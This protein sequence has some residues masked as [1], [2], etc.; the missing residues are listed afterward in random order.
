MKDSKMQEGSLYLGGIISQI[1]FIEG[2]ILTI[3]DSAIAEDRHNKATKDLVK[4]V[5]S[6]QMRWI[7]SL[8]N[9]RTNGG[10]LVH[11][12]EVEVT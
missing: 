4:N 8:A 12:R 1:K 6:R 3:I 9:G 2:D 11:Y 10:E 7:S 5:F